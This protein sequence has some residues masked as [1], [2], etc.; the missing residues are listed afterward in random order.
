MT[1]RS[2]ARPIAFVLV[3][4]LAVVASSGDTR[5]APEDRGAAG[6]ELVLHGA[7]G[8]RAQLEAPHG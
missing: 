2:M 4:Q 8:F 6:L 3:L 1:K 7:D 5:P